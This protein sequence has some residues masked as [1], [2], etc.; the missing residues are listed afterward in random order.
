MGDMDTDPDNE[1]TECS[2]SSRSSQA[3][4]PAF[5]SSEPVLSAAHPI[6]ELPICVQEGGFPHFAGEEA[7]STEGWLYRESMAQL[8]LSLPPAPPQ[9]HIHIGYLPSPAMC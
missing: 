5:A 6:C 9:R 8:G 3:C 4:L 2:W 1:S 7:V